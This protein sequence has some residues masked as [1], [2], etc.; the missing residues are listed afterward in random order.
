MSTEEESKPF[1]VVDRGSTGQI[2]SGSK[3]AHWHA[4]IPQQTIRQDREPRVRGQRLIALCSEAGPDSIERKHRRGTV[5]RHRRWF[6]SYL[7]PFHRRC[8]LSAFRPAAVSAI[9]ERRRTTT[10][11]KKKTKNCYCWSC[12][13]ANALLGIPR[14][15]LRR[16]DRL[17]RQ[18]REGE[19]RGRGELPR[20]ALGKPD[21][22]REPLRRHRS[23][24]PRIPDRA[25][26]PRRSRKMP[27][28]SPRPRRPCTREGRRGRQSPPT[29]LPGRPRRPR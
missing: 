6:A 15:P 17:P 4:W 11:T 1:D 14:D 22:H 20:Q 13:Y 10:T 8:L 19:E 9:P 21:H 3:Q 12:F 7:V 23:A 5:S 25:R 26:P 2:I 28:I 18:G 16:R 24:R 27:T 29:C